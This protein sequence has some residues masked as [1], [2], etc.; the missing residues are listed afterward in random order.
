MTV[1][2]SIAIVKAHNKWRRGDDEDDDTPMVH[3]KILGEAL[4]VL[5]AF[6]EAKS[7]GKGNP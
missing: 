3:P 6:A 4:D 2:E 1:A 5:I 7:D